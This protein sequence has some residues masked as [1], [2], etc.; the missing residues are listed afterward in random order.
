MS[1]DTL[2]DWLAIVNTSVPYRYNDNFAGSVHGGGVLD[3][4]NRNLTM[5]PDSCNVRLS[6]LTGETNHNILPGKD[7]EAYC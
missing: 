3:D 1:P 2:F 6:M 5:Q 4:G 7:C